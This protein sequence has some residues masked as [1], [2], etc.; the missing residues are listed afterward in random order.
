MEWIW[1]GVIISL[2]LIELISLNFTAIWFIISGIISFILLQLKQ[3]YNIQVSAFLIIGLFFIIVV[4][5]HF[6]DK[7]INRRNEV[8]EKIIKKYP[9]FKKL[10]PSDIKI[11]DSKTNNK[12]N[13]SKGKKKQG[14]K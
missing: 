3:G 7:M 10:I 14:K 8:L 1:L 5:P 9:F 11:S 13:K 6:I 4:R 2:I 12:S